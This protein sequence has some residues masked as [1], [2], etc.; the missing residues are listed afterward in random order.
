[1]GHEICEVALPKNVQDDLPFRMFLASKYWIDLNKVFQKK[2]RYNLRNIFFVQ[3]ML[4]QNET[5]DIFHGLA[6]KSLK[7]LKGGTGQGLDLLAENLWS[8]LHP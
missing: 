2:N 6:E 3:K 5:S 8:S 7:N 4:Q 1:M